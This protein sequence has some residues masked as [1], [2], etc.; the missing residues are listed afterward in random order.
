MNLISFIVS[1]ELIIERDLP[2]VQRELNELFEIE[3]DSS[4]GVLSRKRTVSTMANPIAGPSPINSPADEHTA[5]RCT[6]LTRSVDSLEDFERERLEWHALLSGMLLLSEG[7]KP[8]KS[9]QCNISLA[10]RSRHQ[11]FTVIVEGKVGHAEETP[12]TQDQRHMSARK[13][14]YGPKQNPLVSTSVT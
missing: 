8:V 5:Y 3:I 13:H 7:M 14:Y 12:P 10:L 1:Q 6:T 4:T 9:I 11:V 2:E